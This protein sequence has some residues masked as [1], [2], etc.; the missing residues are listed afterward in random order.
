MSGG[1]NQVYLTAALA[2]QAQRAAQKRILQP[3]P[4]GG[5]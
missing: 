5:G 3:G 2:Q 1:M 4:G